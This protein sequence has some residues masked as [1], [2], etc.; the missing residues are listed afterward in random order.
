MN[1]PLI[2]GIISACIS[3]VYFRR[4]YRFV[5]KGIKTTA[6][7]V[8][9]T[10]KVDGEGDTQ[11]ETTL[12]YHAGNRSYHL[13]TDTSD[14]SKSVTGYEQMVIYNP[15]VPTQVEFINLMSIYPVAIGAAVVAA[16]FLWFAFLTYLGEVFLL[17]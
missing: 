16:P 10:T 7:V 9:V 12:E 13:K 5:R 4:G 17:K 2:I 1:I 6:T 15:D 3:L 8:Y 11:Y 14:K